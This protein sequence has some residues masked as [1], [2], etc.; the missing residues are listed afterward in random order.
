MNSTPSFARAQSDVYNAT[1]RAVPVRVTQACV[2]CRKQ[3]LKV[4]R[5]LFDWHRWLS[6][7]AVRCYST[8]HTLHPC[9]SPLRAT[10]LER[11]FSSNAHTSP[12]S[13]HLP[14]S[15]FVVCLLAPPPCSMPLS[16][17][18]LQA[19]AAAAECLGSIYCHVHSL[20]SSCGSGAVCLRA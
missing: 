20:P 3:K 9:W 4:G 12:Q 8:V 11:R 7:C 13:A 17:P 19:H 2:R 5:T 14:C 15:A 18:L 1:S 6:R 16:A 10:Q